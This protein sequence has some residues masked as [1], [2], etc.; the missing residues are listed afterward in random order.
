MFETVAFAETHVKASVMEAVRAE[1][2]KGG[3]KMVGTPASASASSSSGSRG[4][5][6]VVHTGHI[7]A[8]SWER[9]R[10]A[11]PRA[12]EGFCPSTLH[13]KRG[14]VALL[15]AYLFP[16]PKTGGINTSRVRAVSRFV[17]SLADPWIICADWNL[18]PDE[19]TKSGLLEVWDGEIVTP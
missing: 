15:S 8:T 19:L 1:L 12:I 6:W 18:E 16:G 4:G 17:C 2:L 11:K 10:S 14:N 7:A 9:L 13:L 5:E 3:W